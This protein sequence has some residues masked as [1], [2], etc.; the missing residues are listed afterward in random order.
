MG[1]VEDY[2]LLTSFKILLQIDE[3]S[4]FIEIRI[5]IENDMAYRRN[6]VPPFFIQNIA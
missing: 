6:E 4:I 3:K 1:N 5:G 2:F